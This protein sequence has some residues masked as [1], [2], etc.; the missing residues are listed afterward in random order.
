MN[1]RSR[2]D[3]LERRHPPAAESLLVSIGIPDNG[4]DERLAD[5]D[6]VRF[7][8]VEIYRA[9]GKKGDRAIVLPIESS[10]G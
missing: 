8:S 3:R 7:G 6:T 2:I 9:D 5:C 1:L 10:G 4:R